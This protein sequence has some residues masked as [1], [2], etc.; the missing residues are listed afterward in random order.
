MDL[1]SRY[2]YGMC[3]S[4]PQKNPFA[5]FLFGK[6]RNHSQTWFVGPNL[7]TITTSACN[8]RIFYNGLCKPCYQL[9]KSVDFLS[10]RGPSGPMKSNQPDTE[11]SDVL[12][13]VDMSQPSGF[14]SASSATS[15]REKF[16]AD[17]RRHQ[18]AAQPSNNRSSFSE[19]Q[20][21]QNRSY[22]D[23]H[24]ENV[25]TPASLASGSNTCSC[26]CQGWGEIVVRR[27]TGKTS[28]IVR[29]ENA[30]NM[31]CLS[32][33]SPEMPFPDLLNVYN[34]EIHNAMKNSNKSSNISSHHEE[35]CTQFSD[36]MNINSNNNL[37]APNSHH[38]IIS[39]SNRNSA[40]IESQ[41]TESLKE[42]SVSGV[43]STSVAAV[44]AVTSA[45]AAATF[46][47]TS[48]SPEM[49]Q[50]PGASGDLDVAVEV[51]DD[52]SVNLKLSRTVSL[53]KA[54]VPSN[55]R[56][57]VVNR[58]SSFKQ[59][60][61][62]SKKRREAPFQQ[63]A[64]EHKTS[65]SSTSSNPMMMKK[66]N[67]KDLRID[68]NPRSDI[69]SSLADNNGGTPSSPT[70]STPSGSKTPQRISPKTPADDSHTPST[71]GSGS[72]P[73]V[74]PGGRG[75]SNTIASSNGMMR[76]GGGTP[77]TGLKSNQSIGVSKGSEQIHSE[78]HT[79]ASGLNPSFIFLQLYYNQ[80]FNGNV[81]EPLIQVPKNERT[82]CMIRNLD[83]LTPYETHKI[84]VVYV[85]PG[86]VKDKRE[87]LKN[88]FG[89]ARYHL[90]LQKMGNLVRLTDVDQD[91][92]YIGGLSQDG[93]D[94]AYTYCWQDYLT[95]VVFHVATLMPNHERDP[96]ANDKLRHIGNDNVIIIY[97][98]S[99]EDFDVK[100]TFH[101]KVGISVVSYMP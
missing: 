72:S 16:S 33:S 13:S 75:R 44:A 17:R 61:S 3:S 2:T 28:F 99:G 45:A 58:T 62:P 60:L 57:A 4:V 88:D 43:S 83:R 48:S 63:L 79:R 66:H 5:D 101:K 6:E 80:S 91:T 67:T 73:P 40:N 95:Q 74:L 22:D 7:I 26:W 89:S 92:C 21:P 36:G 38:R 32:C 100:D 65:S 81:T 59:P 47:R 12:S 76:S 42:E 52:A 50:A 71:A 77:L 78:T 90:M 11:S 18:S 23:T 54:D 98:D 31:P 64:E 41:L 51:K 82:D 29:A 49:E 53:G 69:K 96:D 9:C 39:N 19:L 85:A 35:I 93:S 84:A 87:I 10:S 27:P 15:S 55:N 37:N 1:L 25:Q 14:S 30:L 8:S 46:R 97:N 56:Q 24:L 20:K 86:Q 34:P 68:I 94:G 70:K